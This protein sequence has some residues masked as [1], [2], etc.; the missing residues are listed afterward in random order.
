MRPLVLSA[1]TA[2]A[3]TIAATVSPLAA[4]EPLT[5]YQLYNQLIDQPFHYRGRE[6]GR[7]KEGQIVYGLKGRLM[8]RTRQGYQD[9]GTWQILGG[10]MCTRVKI[11]RRGARKCFS[12]TPRPDGSYSTSHQY[13][14][15]PIEDRSYL[16]S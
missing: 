7:R 1:V 16:G 13:R 11:G 8:I 15:T 3:V 5:S 14:L 12:V 6:N 4:A 10:K 9:S 2:F